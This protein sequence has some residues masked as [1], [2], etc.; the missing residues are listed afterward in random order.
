[1]C[2]EEGSPKLHQFGPG[3]RCDADN[4]HS[5]LAF[6]RLTGPQLAASLSMHSG[7]QFAVSAGFGAG[8]SLLLSSRWFGSNGMD[9]RSDYSARL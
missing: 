1:M 7:F 8:T 9:V 4:C 6:C 3:G 5:S 2:P